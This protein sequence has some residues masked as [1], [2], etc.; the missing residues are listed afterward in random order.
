ML[1]CLKAAS[2]ISLDIPACD[3]G[4]KGCGLYLGTVSALGP[5][6]KSMDPGRLN[7]NHWSTDNG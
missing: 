7:G 4:V 2:E 5:V 6:M 3:T 1:G